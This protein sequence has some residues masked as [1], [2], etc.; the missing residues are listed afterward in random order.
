MIAGDGPLED[1]LRRDIDAGRLRVRLLGRRS[2]V[3]DLLAAADL[4]LLPSV[5]EARSLTAQEALR[6]G[7]ALVCT[8]TGGMGE[9]VGDAART[10]EVGDASDLAAAV[11][12]LIENPERR[13]A[14]AAAGRARA[15][16]FPTEA[17]TAA[18]LTALYAELAD[19]RRGGSAAL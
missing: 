1:Q 5:W 8:T 19:A 6:A 14:L 2:D 4:V 17:D 15:E 9:L 12:E 11:I 13:A 10:I 7:V 16:G 3:P 18:A